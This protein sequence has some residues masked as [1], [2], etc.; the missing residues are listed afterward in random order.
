MLSPTKNFVMP[1]DGRPNSA[2]YVPEYRAPG[3]S[4]AVGNRCGRRRR[5]AAL[6]LPTRAHGA[7]L[8]PR[9]GRHL[10]SADRLRRGRHD[11]QRGAPVGLQRAAGRRREPDA[12]T[13]QRPQFRICR[14]RPAAGRHDRGSKIQG[15]QSNHI[16]ST[17]KHFAFNDQETEPQH[18]R[19]AD[20][21][22]APRASPTCWRSRSPIEIGKPG[23]VMCS[24]N[25]VNGAYACENDWLLNKVL[26]SDWGFKGYVMSDWGGDAFDRRGGQCRPRPGIRLAVRRLRLFRRRAAARRVNNGHVDQSAARRHGAPH[27][28]RHVRQR[29]VRD[30]VTGDKSAKIDFRRPCACRRG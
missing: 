13:A 14:R 20:R 8:G 11:R 29:P 6:G 21:R 28:V 18:D 22:D 12:R 3:H 4:A 10:G 16:I 23:S 5:D 15:I 9:T 19:V 26:K 25:R 17:L 27:P 24:Y 1:A 30:P 7:A 2:G